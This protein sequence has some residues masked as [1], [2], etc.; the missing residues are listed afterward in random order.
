MKFIASKGADYKA[1]QGG[2]GRSELETFSNKLY[3]Q[4]DDFT[5]IMVTKCSF[6]LVNV[7][8]AK[9]MIG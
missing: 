2:L 8:I 9:Q 7:M 6:I 5:Y 1:S 4:N 3:I